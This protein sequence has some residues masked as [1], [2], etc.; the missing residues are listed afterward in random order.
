M[1]SVLNNLYGDVQTNDNDNSRSKKISVFAS[2]LLYSTPYTVFCV[3]LIILNIALLIWE[4]VE[5]TKK[6]M[7]DSPIFLVLEIT[8]NLALLGEVLLRVASQQ[9]A[10]CKYWGNIFDCVVLVASFVAIILFLKGDSIFEEIGEGFSLF[11]LFCRYCIAFLRVV[12]LVK[13]QRN[14]IRT[15]IKERVDL[16]V[17]G[18]PSHYD[19][20]SSLHYSSNERS[21]NMNDDDDDS[22]NEEEDKL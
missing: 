5:I 1:A 4:V 3:I 21:F 8:V 13:N 7:P 20:H 14:Y 11:L 12:I 6:E 2:R 18:P 17:V 15:Q 22:L 9:K 16:S 19:E 10:Y